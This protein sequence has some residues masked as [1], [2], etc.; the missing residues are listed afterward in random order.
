MIHK[1]VRV[2]FAPAP[3]GIMHL[4]NVRT[5]L[6]NYLFARKHNGTSILRIE[7][8]DAQRNFD[9]NAEIICKD[10]A[11]LGISYQEGPHL[12]GPHQ[13]YIQSQR[14]NIY[15]KHLTLLKEKNAIYRC[16]CSEQELETKRQRQQALHLPPRYDRVCLSLLAHEIENKIAQ[17]HP[18]IWRVKMDHALSE[19]IHDLAHGP[20]QFAFKNFSD[21]PITRQDGSFTFLFVNFIDDMLM[22][23]THVLRGEDH[24]TNT[25]CQIM[26][27]LIFNHPIP[28]FWHLPI[29]C[30]IDGKKLSKRDFGFS[31]HTLRD[32]GFLPEA[33]TNYLGI[34]GTSCAEEI[35][36]MDDMVNTINL[37]KPSA[38][39]AIKY[40]SEKLRWVNHKWIARYSTL[41]LAKGC[42]PFLEAV[43][44][45]HVTKLSNEQLAQLLAPIH[46][47]IVTLKDSIT[48]LHFVFIAPELTASHFESCINEHN[49]LPIKT[50]I[51]TVIHTQTDTEL[52]SALLSAAKKANIA[53]KDMFHFLRLSMTGSINGVNVGS[54]IQ[55]LGTTEAKKRIQQG[56]NL[57]E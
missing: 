55:M 42:R 29:I 39:G 6:M 9:P 41:E 8:T 30:N 3:T 13:P 50:V 56:L 17:G 31:L 26:L 20:I 36:S 10:L 7:D 35:L 21:F 1:N 38:T 32:E 40:D 15:E 47:D 33:I 11:W 5:A 27:Y 19:T 46:S 14:G 28:L 45:E 53:T 12:G 54:I 37:S 23:I 4:G 49:R 25:A 18:F 16:F 24:I 34:I 57:L 43:Y 52:L 44:H 51:T 2:R 22:G 48:A